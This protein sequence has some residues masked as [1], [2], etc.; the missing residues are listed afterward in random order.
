[1]LTGKA[2]KTVLGSQQQIGCHQQLILF[3][4]LLRFFFSSNT[5]FSG[6]R[7]DMKWLHSVAMKKLSFEFKTCEIDCFIVFV[8]F[9][10]HTDRNA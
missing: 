2:S 7:S 5:S 1:M 4:F 3:T 6:C 8:F 10:L 9:S